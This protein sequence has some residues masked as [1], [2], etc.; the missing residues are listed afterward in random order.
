M[1]T[2]AQCGE[3]LPTIVDASSSTPPGNTGVVELSLGEELLSMRFYGHLVWGEDLLDRVSILD[4]RIAYSPKVEVVSTKPSLEGK[5]RDDVVS[6]SEIARAVSW[7]EGVLADTVGVVVALVKMSS[8]ASENDEMIDLDPFD[9]ESFQNEEVKTKRRKRSNVWAFF[10]M[11][12][13][14]EI[15]DGKP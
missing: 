12:P 2:L 11:V 15:N 7:A 3:V 14:S 8:A 4:S 9:S 5:G 6:E 13:D 10:E 1:A